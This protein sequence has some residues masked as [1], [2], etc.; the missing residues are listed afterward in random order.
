MKQ[1]RQCKLQVRT[2]VGFREPQGMG[3]KNKKGRGK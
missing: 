2:L 1:A 3:N